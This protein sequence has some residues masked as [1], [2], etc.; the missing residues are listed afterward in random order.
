MTEQ[1]RDFSLIQNV[2]EIQSRPDFVERVAVA[3]QGKDGISFGQIVGQYQFRNKVK[4]GIA[5]CGTQHA[6]G[7]LVSLSSGQE[8]MIGHV[9]G[10][11]NF[12]VDFT[13]KAREFRALRVHA[14]QFQTLKSA[15][16]QLTALKAAFEYTLTHTG[17]LSF[18][19]IKNGI[20]GLVDGGLN[21]W[22]TQRIRNDVSANGMIFEEVFKT[23]EEKDIERH[24][25]GDDSSER[26]RYVSDTKKMLVA[27]IDGFDVV[28]QWHEAEKLK[29][30]FEKLHREIKNPVGLP[31]DAFKTL[32]R[33]LKDY[34]QNLQML[35]S[36]CLRGNKLFQR[37]NLLQL[38][39]LFHHS[40][41]I[42]KIEQFANQ[43]L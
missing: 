38:K 1:S 43:Y 41:E 40:D 3:L 25:K 12:G 35:R 13:N 26:H 27:E 33:K 17:R 16:E 7:Y 36:Y 20:K 15:Y 28:Y 37:E 42:R 29:D 23:K 34:E 4:C 19:D 21:Y 18:V 6:R 9:C 10:R 11:N 39:C 2:E 30:Y 14:D 31:D 32:I 8:I 5:S 24:M 22:M